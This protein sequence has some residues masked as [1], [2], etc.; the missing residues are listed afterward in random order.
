MQA[1]IFGEYLHIRLPAVGSNCP[2]ILR[3]C[4]HGVRR[5]LVDLHFKPS[6]H[7]RHKSMC[8][9]A[10]TGNKKASK[11]TNSPSGSGT[12]SAPGPTQHRYQ[13]NQAAASPARGPRKSSKHQT[14]RYGQAATPSP[15]NH[16]WSPRTTPWSAMHSQQTKKKTLQCTVGGG[17][18]SA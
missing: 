13:S 15:Q 7:L 16:S 5:Q 6:Q 14:P 4:H 1:I 11:T 9:E 10:K 12:S 18:R 3:Q 2:D 17:T 8:R